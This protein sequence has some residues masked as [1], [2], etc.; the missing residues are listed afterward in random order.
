MI[1]WLQEAYVPKIPVFELINVDDYGKPD[2]FYSQIINARS[3]KSILR[4]VFSSQIYFLLF[5]AWK[6]SPVVKWFSCQGTAISR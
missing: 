3:F 2:G 5:T 4:N 6:L 1:F